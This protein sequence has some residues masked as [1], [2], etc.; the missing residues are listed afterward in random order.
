[1]AD[2]A[3]KRLQELI[4]GLLDI[5][6]QVDGEHDGLPMSTPDGVFAVLNQA[7]EQIGEAIETIRAAV[8]MLKQD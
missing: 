7:A 2:E 1:M 4:D 6:E 5:W 8:I 3:A